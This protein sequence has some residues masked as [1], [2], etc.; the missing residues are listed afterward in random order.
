MLMIDLNQML[1]HSFLQ[2]EI[3][4]LSHKIASLAANKSYAEAKLQ[5]LEDTA[6]KVNVSPE[7]LLDIVYNYKMSEFVYCITE[8]IS[9]C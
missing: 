8:R 5:K 2:N 3:D 9:R 4:Q 1:I 6:T 7:N